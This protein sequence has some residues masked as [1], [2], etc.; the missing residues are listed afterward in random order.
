MFSPAARKSN[1]GTL[2]DRNHS[3]RAP[4]YTPTA[5]LG[6]GRKASFD[7]SIPNRP[8]TG[9]PAPWA[10]RLSVLARISPMKNSE[11]MDDEDPIQPVF[12]GEFPQVV[13]EEQNNLHR[14]H[15]PGQACIAGGMDKGT[16]ISWMICGSRLFLWSYL[17]PASSNKCVI[18]DIPSNVSQNLDINRNSNLGCSWLLRVISW[19]YGNNRNLQRQL[20]SAGILLCN[21]KSGA[22]VYWPDIYPDGGADPVTHL[23]SLEELGVAV[24][25][26]NGKSP[27]RRQHGLSGH[28]NNLIESIS[29]NS[30]IATPVPNKKQVCIALA[31]CSNGELWHFKCGPGEICPKKVCDSIL[32]SSSSVTSSNQAIG[33]MGYPRSLIWRSPFFSLEEHNRQFF[34]LT[35]HEIQCFRIELT[36]NFEVSRLW[37]QEIIGADGDLGIK[38]DL[39]GQKKIWPLDIRVDDRGKEITILVATYCKDRV[40]SSSYMRYSLLTMHYRSGMDFLESVNSHERVLEK[41]DPIQVIIPKA[42]VEEEEVLFSMRLQMGGKPLGSA[43]ILSGDG[44]ATVYYYWRQSTRLYQFDLPYDA[45]KVLDASVFPSLDDSEAGAWVLLTEKAGIWAI[46]E[47]AILLDGAEPP[48]RSMSLKGSSK[49]VSMEDEKRNFM[50]LGSVDTRRTSS[51]ARHT[52]DREHDNYSGTALGAVRDEVAEGLVSQLFHDFLLSGQVDGSLEKLQNSGAFERDGEMNAFAWASKSIVDT[53][54]KHWTTTRGAEIVALAAVSTQLMEK[55]QKHQKYLQFLALSKCHEE[56]CLKLR[57]ALQIIMEHGE[58]L[59][60]MI[61]LREL[62]NMI[63]ESRAAGVTSQHSGLE[64][65]VSG[66][67]W[68]LI[69]MVGERARRNTVLLMDRDNAEVFY[70]KVSELEEVFYCLDRHLDYIISMEQPIKVQVQRACELSNSCATLVQ[71]AMHY[72]KENHM[73][74]PPHDGLMPWYGQH[75]VISGLWSLA[76][77]MIQILN[78]YEID[79]SAKSDICSHLEVLGDIMLEAYLGAITVKVELEEEHKALV[80]EYWNRR[81]ALLDSLHRQ[82]KVFVDAQIQDSVDDTPKQ[83][84]MILRELSANLLS[85]AR[86]HECYKILWIICSDLNDSTLLKNLMHESVGP[87]GGFSYFVFKQLYENGQFSKLLIL[88]EEFPEELS[89]FLK[90]HLD[91]LWLHEIFLHRFSSASKTLHVLS[92][93]EDGSSILDTEDKIKPGY[94]EAELM[95]PERKRLLYLSKIAAVAG[96][97]ANY[98]TEVERINADLMILKLQENILELLP[99]EEDKQKIGQRLLPP[100]DLIR[101]CL[102]AQIPQLSLKA[103]DVFAWTSSSFRTHNRTLLEECWKNAAE[104]DDWEK[105]Y[106]FSAAQGWSDDDTFRVLEKTLLFHASRRC[107]GPKSQSFGGGFDEVLPLRRDNTKPPNLKDSAASVESILMQHR[108]FADAGKLMLTAVM[109]GSTQVDVGTRDN[110]ALIG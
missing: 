103:F 62:Q 69:Q 58:K 74:Y 93:S 20:K 102:K 54:A 80:E 53:L 73:W 97:D 13:R 10:S 86:R 51:E 91:L 47:R 79:L 6:G 66:S 8:K 84:E 108:D 76:F 43:V 12:V 109:L 7:S 25:L 60:A 83:K 65:E 39:A 94:A 40:S 2:K 19:D 3:P 33:G 98:S 56:L 99:N 38:K 49:E 44:T 85:I 70:S 1:H 75:A 52:A 55:L 68:D 16:S 27:F 105:L 18:L 5:T 26:G 45:G 17:S 46:P 15:A 21:R 34:L 30:L 35:D 72:K 90:D 37:S 48:V 82:I 107:Y 104:L 95:L 41:K 42:R 59:A 81:D 71:S 50:K 106:R 4:D 23:E 96:E 87:K 67:L 57:H 9:T 31:S 89:T 88:G 101:L 100:G 110:V 22:I 61:Q 29:F 28:E 32:D 64:R 77:F 14:K 78:E 92:L 63:S 11:K 36:S 24:S